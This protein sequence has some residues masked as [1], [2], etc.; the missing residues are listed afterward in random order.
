M[1]G[2]RKGTPK[3]WGEEGNPKEMGGEKKLIERN[4]GGKKK[5]RKGK[6]KKSPKNER[7]KNPK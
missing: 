3:K 2:E 6:R 4:W 5:E 1:N 7:E